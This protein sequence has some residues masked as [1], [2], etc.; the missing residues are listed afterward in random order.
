MA[1]RQ[2]AMTPTRSERRQAAIRPLSQEWSGSPFSVMQRMADEMDRLFE[3]FGF[4]RSWL[5]R[6]GHG[7]EEGLQMWAPD[8]DVFQK[9][10]QLTIRADLPGMKR[11]EIS[12]EVTDDAVLIQGER[13]H[14]Q[15]EEREGLYRRERGYGSFSR[16]IPLPEGAMSEQAKAEFREGV[17][18]IT[19]PA[20]PVSKGRRIEISEA[21]K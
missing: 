10:N 1:E 4:G 20:P 19:M 21:K 3:D 8:V 11:D 13:K 9:D 16:V 2:T 5:G 6:P 18:E 15:Q 7:R 12:V 14:E 17:L